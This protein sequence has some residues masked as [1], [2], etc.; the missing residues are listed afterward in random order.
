MNVESQVRNESG[1]QQSITLSA[2]V[3]DA[4]GMVR[5]K[6]EGDTSDLVAA[7]RKSFTAP[8]RWRTRDSG[9]MNDPVSLRRLFHPHRERQGGG[10]V[11]DATGFRKTEFK[12]G[13]GTGG[14]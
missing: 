6:F 11:Q 13:A 3:V 10:R 14:V 2:V 5:A 4:D 1:D 12:G 9:T 7:R 8:G